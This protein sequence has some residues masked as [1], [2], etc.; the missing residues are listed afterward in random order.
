MPPT[1]FTNARVVLPHEVVTGS[2]ELHGDGA[3]FV[4]LA[5]EASRT[6]ALR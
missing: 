4:D 6:V 1:T 2:V 3:E 5:A